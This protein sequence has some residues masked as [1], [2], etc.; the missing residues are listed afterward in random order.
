MRAGSII[1]AGLV[2][3]CCADCVRN[4]RS[5]PGSGG[6]DG[7]AI[8]DSGDKITSTHVPERN[9]T[10]S[11]RR[12]LIRRFQRTSR[13]CS[14]RQFDWMAAQ[15]LRSVTA[16]SILR[17]GSAPAWDASIL[18]SATD[19]GWHSVEVEGGPV[20]T[21]VTEAYR[22]LGTQ[23]LSVL[24]NPPESKGEQAS[25]ILISLPE[26]LSNSEAAPM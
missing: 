2:A 4:R 3:L 11:G 12:G 8:R 21:C 10:L 20:V 5:L 9:D 13:A 24:W 17:K 19:T 25:R 16:V 22:G 26:T 14:E 1:F 7:H 23:E 15:G 6:A 18:L